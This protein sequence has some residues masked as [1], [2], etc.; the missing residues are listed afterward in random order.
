MTDGRGTTSFTY[1]HN[2]RLVGCTD[3]DGVYTA[4]GFSIEYDYDIAGNRTQ[5]E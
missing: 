2:N 3:P 5:V 1:D 4:D